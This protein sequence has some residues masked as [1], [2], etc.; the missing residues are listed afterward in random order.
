M[1]NKNTNYE[2]TIG[3]KAVICVHVNAENEKE[4][5]EIALKKFKDGNKFNKCELQDDNYK[6]DGICDMDATWK[7]YDK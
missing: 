1:K 6:V 4:A 3:Y 7:M 2:I 5:K